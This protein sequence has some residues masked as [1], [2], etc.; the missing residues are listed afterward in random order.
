MSAGAGLLA[1]VRSLISE[2]TAPKN[3]SVVFSA[4]TILIMGGGA[5]G[6]P[7]YSETYS[8]GVRLGPAWVGLPLEVAGA[9]LAI[10]FC[11]ALFIRE[12]EQGQYEIIS[13]H[14]EE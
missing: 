2:S 11:M 13:E 5:I 1:V 4:M 9:M 3:I 6:G 14:E 7:I 12:P 10:V 8:A